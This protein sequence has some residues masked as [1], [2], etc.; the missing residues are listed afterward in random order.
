M[1]EE[2][3]VIEGIEAMRIKH[4]THLTELK[5]RTMACWW[6]SRITGRTEPDWQGIM[7]EL[8]ALIEGAERR[9]DIAELNTLTALTP[10][11]LDHTDA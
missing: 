6:P 9:G 5:Q 11:V 3:R 7:G 1:R 8:D 2:P 10:Y 4:T